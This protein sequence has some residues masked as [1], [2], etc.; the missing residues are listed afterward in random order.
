[1]KECG[2]NSYEW[3]CSS[4]LKGKKTFKIN[5]LEHPYGGKGYCG[6]T[7]TIYKSCENYKCGIATYKKCRTKEC[8]VEEYNNCYHYKSNNN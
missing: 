6:I 8:G 7:K 3:T 2:I 1:M 4:D 5:S